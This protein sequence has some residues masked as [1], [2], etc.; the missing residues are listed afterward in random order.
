ME[1]ELH[2]PAGEH[3]ERKK[4]VV[5]KRRA[6]RVA[7]PRLSAPAKE[8]TKMDHPELE[9]INQGNCCFA[10]APATGCVITGSVC[11]H[12]Y[13]GGLQAALQSKPD[14]IQR[15]NAARRI[16]ARIVTDKKTG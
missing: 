12:P 4:R 10:C 16:I 13:K 15:Y 1:T 8:T 11:G 7:A 9:G 5:K 3:P 6:R 2:N 14:V